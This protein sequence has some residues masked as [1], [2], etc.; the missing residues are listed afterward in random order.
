MTPHVPETT[1]Q[2]LK[3]FWEDGVHPFKGSVL[4]IIHLA[5]NIPGLSLEVVLRSIAIIYP[6]FETTE[7]T[8][9]SMVVLLLSSCGVPVAQI[10]VS[11]GQYYLSLCLNTILSMGINGKPILGSNL[12]AELAGENM[13][14]NIFDVDMGR[15]HILQP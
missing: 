1:H 5:I 6:L 15:V 3:S 14:L 12:V 4:P 10:M 7:I 13:P 2:L 9:E 11:N 8:T